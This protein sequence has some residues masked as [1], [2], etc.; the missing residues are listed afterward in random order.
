MH[1]CD[2]SEATGGATLSATGL[3]ERP[4]DTLV[5]TSAGQ[6]AATLSIVLQ[7]TL[8]IYDPPYFGDG[9]RC[10]GGSLKRLYVKSAVGGVVTAPEGSDPSV[11]ARSAALGDVIQPGSTRVYQIYYRDSNPI[12]CP[13]PPGGTFNVS[14]GLLV[15][16]DV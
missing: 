11:S 13:G 7:G 5:L 8:Y 3:A 15:A 14:S 9:L 4:D 1:G 2:N 10:T 16:W 6:R 12:F